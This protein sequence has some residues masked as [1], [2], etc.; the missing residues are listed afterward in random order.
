M[1]YYAIRFDSP[2]EYELAAIYITDLGLENHEYVS[3]KQYYDKWL[4]KRNSYNSIII[5]SG[6]LVFRR[7]YNA[8]NQ[9]DGFF[10]K[11]FTLSNI[12]EAKPYILEACVPF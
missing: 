6:L 11:V 3:V 5:K 12:E 1:K 9:H 8:L 2:V 7:T 4:K 10:D